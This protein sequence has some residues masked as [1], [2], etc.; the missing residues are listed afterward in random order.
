MQLKYPKIYIKYIIIFSLSSKHYKLDLSYYTES[1]TQ[2]NVLSQLVVH[3]I[4]LFRC[5]NINSSAYF[6]ELRV[7]LQIPI[8]NLKDVKK[9]C[10]FFSKFFKA[11]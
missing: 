9:L 4:D 10:S 5:I 6:N 11:S 7:K 3:G 1:I 8:A 2:H